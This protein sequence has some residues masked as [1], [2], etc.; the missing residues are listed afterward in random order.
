MS[1]PGCVFHPFSDL[2]KI[3]GIRFAHRPSE[4]ELSDLVR[5]LL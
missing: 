4:G 3:T 5:G 1:L 2:E